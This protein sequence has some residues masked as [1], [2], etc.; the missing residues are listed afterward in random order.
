MVVGAWGER[1]VDQWAGAA[2]VYRLSDAEEWSFY[3]TIRASDSNANDYFGI[4]VA[5]HENTLVVGA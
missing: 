2:Y 4:S 1:T 3:Q 5:I